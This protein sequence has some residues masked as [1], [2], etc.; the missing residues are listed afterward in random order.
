MII[1]VVGILLILYGTLTK[2]YSIW[3]GMLFVL[4]IMGFQE[5]VPGDYEAY[6]INFETGGSMVG[7]INSSVKEDEYAFIWILNT[8]PRYLNYHTYV[9]ITSI[10]QC[11]IMTLFIKEVGDKRYHKFGVLLVFFTITIMMLRM[12]AMRQGYAVDLMLLS[13]LLLYKRRYLLSLLP[14]VLAYGF[15]NSVTLMMPFYIV[16]WILVFIQRKDKKN[17]VDKQVKVEGEKAYKPAIIVAIS[18]LFFYLLK[19]T[20]FNSYINPFLQNMD[21]FE[22]SSHLEEYVVDQRIAWWIL[23][24]YTVTVFFLTLYYVNEH[25]MFKKYISI[26]AIAGVFLYIGVDGY[27]NLMRMYMYFV[28]FSVALFPNVAAM[29]RDSYGKDKANAYVVFNMLFLIYISS[30]SMLSM[31]FSSGTGYGNYTFSFLNW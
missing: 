24:Y 27:G 6:K 19:Y 23:L 12:K 22:Y 13:F 11:L 7:T 9:L 25:N 8:L 10:I 5:G 14:M 16:L 4:L 28:I 3:V 2:K 15:H 17:A 18:L 31:D 21:S 26:I 30:R 29:I 20:V 1:L